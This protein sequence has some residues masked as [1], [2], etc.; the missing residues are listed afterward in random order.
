MTLVATNEIELL[1]DFRQRILPAYAAGRASELVADEGVGRS[2]VPPGTGAYRDFSHLALEIPLFDAAKCVGCMDCVNACPDTAILG[3]ALP[4]AIL[5]EQLAALGDGDVITEQRGNW[6][7]TRK[8]FEIPS[9]KG[10]E[11]ALFGIFV[12][13][14]K[15][16]G[17]GECVEVCG[18]HDALRMVQK[19]EQLTQAVLNVLT[20]KRYGTVTKETKNLTLGAYGATAVPI[21]PEVM[22]TIC[23]GDIPITHRP[24]DDLAPELE[25][26]KA[27]VGDLA[28]SVEDVL[29]Y[30]MFPQPAREFLTW[31]REG[32]GPERKLVAAVVAAIAIGEKRAPAAPVALTS[33]ESLTSDGATWKNF[34]RLRQMR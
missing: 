20:G 34:G 24:A 5:T 3:K 8:Y 14:T 13:P 33:S 30:V 27:E 2:L 12:D 16:K 11:G 18:S 28:E 6:V 1:E 29:S 31:R 22:K 9:A 32:G 17:C 15:C 4:E 10:Q 21:A 23:D 26:A 19:D 7:K 25:Q